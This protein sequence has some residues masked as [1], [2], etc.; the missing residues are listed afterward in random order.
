MKVVFRVDASVQIGAGHLMRCLT[1]AEEMREHGIETK[2][3]CRDLAGN[4]NA[5]L[6]DKGFSVTV[7][8]QALMNEHSL[9]EISRVDSE[10]TIL[11]LG[12]EMPDWMVVDH[13]GFDFKWELRLR[14]FVGR[15]MAIDD[16]TGR[17]HDCDVLLDQNY[18]DDLGQRYAGLVPPASKTLLGSDYA[19]LRK[20]FG[21]LR[22]HN[23]QKSTLDNIL[24]FFTAGEDQ[25]E[26][27]KAIQ[28]V[29]L[30]GKAKQVDV[31]V[32]NSNPQNAA[33]KNKCDELHWG[34]HCQVDYMPSLIAKADLVVGAGGSSNWERCALGVPAL[35]TI[36]ANNQVAIA[37]AL[38]SAGVVCNLGWFHKLEPVDYANALCSLDS[39]RLADMSENAMRIVDAAGAKRV[40][41]ALLMNN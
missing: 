36:L 21:E 35:V 38:D 17:S 26:T 23:R 27:L 12:G 30:F 41:D 4:L 40:V 25:G 7:L 9:D 22:A 10:Q 14:P 3:I 8:P 39:K 2:F 24:I 19:L 31:V 18:S 11:A 1:L 29:A 6:R 28:G 15:L 16:H 20:E 33:I 37:Q 32:G 13:Y 34:Y 5:S